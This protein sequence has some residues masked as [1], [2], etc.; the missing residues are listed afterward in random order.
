MVHNDINEGKKP[1]SKGRPFAKGNIKGKPRDEILASTGH[2]SSL[3]GEV[4]A[5]NPKSSILEPVKESLEG[6]KELEK[7][8]S[9]DCPETPPTTLPAIEAIAES[10]ALPEPVPVDSIE[11]KQDENILK[12]VLSRKHNRMYRVQIFL[13]DS[14]EIRPTTYTGSA[15]AMGFWNLLKNSLK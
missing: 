8:I 1:R 15:P 13:N 2:Q 7:A 10:K 6:K 3:G 14:I 9:R 4:I 5:S 12:I 11:F